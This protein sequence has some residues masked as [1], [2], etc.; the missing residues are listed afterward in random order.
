MV[1]EEEEEIKELEIVMGN[2]FKE[3]ESSM[4]R[5][6]DHYKLLSKGFHDKKFKLTKVFASSKEGYLNL[7]NTLANLKGPSL[8]LFKISLGD[9]ES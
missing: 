9:V 7:K 4:L 5:S 8:T 1:K 6:L 2:P 3:L